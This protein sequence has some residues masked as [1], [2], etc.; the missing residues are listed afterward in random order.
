MKKHKKILTLLCAFTILAGTAFA[1]VE[2]YN[3]AKV[4]KAK[5]MLAR[6]QQ[7]WDKVGKEAAMTEFNNP[8]TTNFV[9][10][11]VYIYCVDIESRKVSTIPKM[12][13]LLNT[14]WLAFK[15]SDGKAFGKTMYEMA[16]TNPSGMTE[17]KWLNTATGKIQQKAAYYQKVGDQICVASVYKD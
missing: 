10:G 15:D 8:A 2:G 7:L 16:K 11:D 17:Y 5:D 1:Q 13:A 6:A 3:P 14:D 9:D 12:K 4:K